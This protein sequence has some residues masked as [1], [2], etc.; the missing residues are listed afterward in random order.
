MILDSI[1]EIVKEEEQEANTKLKELKLLLGQNFEDEIFDIF[2]ALS[3][4]LILLENS[5]ESYDY[6][7]FKDIKNNKLNDEDFMNIKEN[8]DECL[9]EY[10]KINKLIKF[11]ET[12]INKINPYITLFKNADNLVD[13]LIRKDGT[14]SKNSDIKS[15]IDNIG[16]NINMNLENIKTKLNG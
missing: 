12:P 11:S 8:I 5:K 4:Y 7:K 3:N 15:E 13:T 1:N 6:I 9:D 14:E 2:G 16:V 10:N